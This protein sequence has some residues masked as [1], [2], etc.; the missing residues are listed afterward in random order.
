MLPAERD[1]AY[2]W[3][4]REAAREVVELTVGMNQEEFLKSR[5]VLRATERTLEI[6]GEATRRVS[7]AYRSAH[8]EIP[9]RHIIGLRNLLAH[10]YGRIDH[11]ALFRTAKENIPSLIEMLDR[12]ISPDEPGRPDNKARDG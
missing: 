9:W 6:V 1:E 5:V 4:M 2:L 10:E 12:L 3:D 7:E 11:E 8:P